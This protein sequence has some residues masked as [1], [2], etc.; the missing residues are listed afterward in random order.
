MNGKQPLGGTPDIIY[1]K[2]I[3]TVFL[4]L[5]L[6]GSASFAQ[7]DRRK[8][9]P[10]QQQVGNKGTI[11]GID[12]HAITISLPGNRL[13][14]VQLQDN[15]ILK[16]TSV[17]RDD[18]MVGDTL[19][20]HG[21]CLNNDKIAAF[22]V[23]LTPT[24]SQRAS[25]RPERGSPIRAP[26]VPV[27]GKLVELTP[28]RIET[29]TGAEKEI[30]LTPDT[31]IFRETRI[32][33]ADLVIGDKIHLL[34]GK[35]IVSAS[36]PEALSSSQPSDK[37]PS[38]VILPNAPKEF[39]SCFDAAQM[40]STQDSP[41]GF[42][43]PNMLR[44]SH[45]SW[46]SGYCT[47]MNDL[48]AHWASYGASFSFN[49]NLI[50]G[51][52]TDG[53]FNWERVDRLIKHAQ[54]NNIHII[55]YIKASEPGRNTSESARIIPSLPHDMDGYKK[56]VQATVE[57]YDMDGKHDMPDLKWPV[58]YWSVEDE[59]F[60]KRYFNGTGADYAVLL[61]AAYEA[62][63][64][65]DQ[66][67][68]V[69]CSMVRGTGWLDKSDPR[70]FMKAFFKKLANIGKH[71]PYDILDQHWLGT[72]PKTPQAEQYAVYGEWLED[73]RN[74]A[75]IYGFEKAPFVNLELAG[76]LEP[77]TSHAADLLKRHIYLL[78]S[79]IK[80]I[81]WSGV[82]AAPDA[83]LTPKQRE[84]YFRKVC[85]ISGK[86]VKK[87][88]YYTYKLMVDILDGS[89]WSKTRAIKVAK[90]E[91]IYAF[92]KHDKPIWVAW[93][94]NKR[95]T[96]RIKVPDTIQYVEVIESVPSA[97]TGKDITDYSKVFK[98][99]RKSASNGFV[100]INVDETP[101]FVIGY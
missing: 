48:G 54:A 11:S 2:A 21:R 40:R 38:S 65:A 57:R 27:T 76:T 70:S 75:S 53:E 37:R 96:S 4:I 10:T 20:V 50:Q 73:I 82:K 22:V 31:K 52:K 98:R 35:I 95:S 8:T 29:D 94:D 18:L 33:A 16:Q 45:S 77:E 90:G 1:H 36:A 83:M 81:L 87:P 34:H 93:N 44:F 23:I 12:N 41:F 74:T 24:T 68:K 15:I 62:I 17:Q 55:G 89:D 39:T 97:D 60:A 79:G 92:L 6:S 3:L 88:A 58:K 100:D 67:A 14:K 46:Y 78:A 71:R 28:L 13:K 66:D 84:D 49:W 43:D 9:R 26:N 61:T 64:S 51:K 19:S 72:A 32:Q 91:F 99:E 59:P 42:F 86:G 80:K 5:L 63:K 101:V 56:F 25:S 47:T 85:L 69:I 7:Q 30:I